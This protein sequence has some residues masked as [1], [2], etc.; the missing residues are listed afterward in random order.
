MV[1][2]PW[3]LVLKGT[4]TDD[5]QP[6]FGQF[7]VQ[8]ADCLWHLAVLVMARMLFARGVSVHAPEDHACCV[9]P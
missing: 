5:F 7:V 3:Y 8:V 9:Y 4:Q 2:I 1:L 6:S